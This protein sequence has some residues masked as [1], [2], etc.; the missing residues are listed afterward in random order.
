V[1]LFVDQTTESS[2][3]PTPQLSLN[4]VEM[5]MVREGDSWK[6]EEITSY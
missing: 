6:V 5:V 1:L 4:R 3:N 2:S